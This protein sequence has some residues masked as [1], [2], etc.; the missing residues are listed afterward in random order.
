MET[1]GFRFQATPIFLI[2]QVSARLVG[3]ARVW[4]AGPGA[5][6]LPLVQSRRD[7]PQAGGRLVVAIAPSV[8]LTRWRRR[9]DGGPCAGS[10]RFRACKAR[11]VRSCGPDEVPDMDLPPPARLLL[12][13]LLLLGVLRPLRGDPGESGAGAAGP[14]GEAGV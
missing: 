13:L 5:G 10:G 12:G 1:P 14:G 3:G 2:P 7:A 4:W 8:R 9:G 6:S 11:A